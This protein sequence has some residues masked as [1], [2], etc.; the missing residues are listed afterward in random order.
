MAAGA[1]TSARPM[2]PSLAPITQAML[3]GAGKDSKNWLHSN[4]SYE[5][6]RFYPGKQLNTENVSKLKPAFVFQT[7]V[8]ESM[9][10]APIVDNGVMF[11]TTSFN[12]VY[13]INAATGE[14]YWHYKHKLGP[15]VTVCCG[16]N[17]RGVA[18]L[19][20]CRLVEWH[21]R[22]PQSPQP[23]EGCQSRR[24]VEHVIRSTPG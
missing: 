6:T 18:G 4:G 8:L 17:N 11:L 19:E 5:Q 7:A 16:N 24:T 9:E 21:L 3:D 2:S 14:E 1:T 22:E 20:L 10:T 13:A 12:H 15:I 23:R